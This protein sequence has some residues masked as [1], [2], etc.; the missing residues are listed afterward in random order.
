MSERGEFVGA[1]VACRQSIA[2]SPYEAASHSMLGFLLERSGDFVGAMKAYEKTLQIAPDSPLERDGLRRLMAEQGATQNP[3][4]AVFQFDENELFDEDA[5][6]KSDT[7]TT[8][9]RNAPA[10]NAP[11]P[12]TTTQ[13]VTSTVRPALKAT[14]MVNLD[15][16][17]LQSPTSRTP[18]QISTP[19]KTATPRAL[20]QNVLSRDDVF[21]SSPSWMSALRAYP[22]FWTRSLPLMSVAGTGL[23]WMLWAQSAANRNVSIS[24]PVSQTIVGNIAP[25]DAAA[26]NV[27]VDSNNVDLNNNV[28]ASA[29]DANNAVTATTNIT[30]VNPNSATPA[31]TAAPNPNGLFSSSW[32]ISNK[33]QSSPSP[34]ASRNN[35]QSGGRV[36]NSRTN[37]SP[38]RVRREN[39]QTTSTRSDSL[40]ISRNAARPPAET[41]ELAPLPPASLPS[42][43]NLPPAP[44]T[45]LPR[46]LDTPRAAASTSNQGGTNND[47][48]FPPSSDGNDNSGNGGLAPFNGALPQFPNPT[49]NSQPSVRPQRSSLNS[50]NNRDAENAYRY[51][52]RALLHIERGDNA[53]AASDFGSAI[54]FYN[55]QIAKGIGVADAQR[56]LEACRSGLQLVS[57][58]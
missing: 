35:A 22:T 37:S 5:L 42:S 39:A 45:Q 13:V 33:P 38:N 51:Q 23:L 56:G 12:Q 52:T 58:R 26:N 31:A 1:I 48:Q 20:S 43:S 14:P 10:P 50:L 44:V 47:P 7:L 11:A 28:V 34:N 41:R 21:A 25:D 29:A 57:S 54:G 30:N 19:A 55:R 2:L 53:K 9:T 46:V 32:T 49:T 24:S 27:A 6:P 3:K 36:T 40:Q 16:S 8:S 18:I 15:S 4:N 17:V